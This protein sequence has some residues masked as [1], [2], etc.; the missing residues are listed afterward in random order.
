[1]LKHPDY[2]GEIRVGC[3]CASKMI[4]DYVTP[5]ERER[6]LKNRVNRRKNFMK[7]EW[8][9]KPETGNYTLRYKGDYITIMKSKFGPGWGIIYKGEQQW[10]LISPVNK[11]EFLKCLRKYNPDIQVKEPS[12]M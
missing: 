4:C 11:K 1:M 9:R 3:D 5:Q 2:D 7:Q 8:Y 10:L 6:N 12:I